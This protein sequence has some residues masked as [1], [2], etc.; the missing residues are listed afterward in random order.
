MSEWI[1]ETFKVSGR[2]EG[3]FMSKDNKGKDESGPEEMIE[4]YK[5]KHPTEA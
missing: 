2:D 5:E 3:Q 1:E 4:A